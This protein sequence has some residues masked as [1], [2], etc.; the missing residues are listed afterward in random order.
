MYSSATGTWILEYTIPDQVRSGSDIL[1][2]PSQVPGNQY[3][4]FPPAPPQLCYGQ[5]NSTVVSIPN[6]VNSLHAITLPKVHVPSTRTT[7]RQQRHSNQ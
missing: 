6:N 2:V 3:Q 5:K 7:T 1:P 4:V